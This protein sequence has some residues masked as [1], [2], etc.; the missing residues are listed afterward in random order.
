MLFI[1][2]RTHALQEYISEQLSQ[3]KQLGLIA[4]LF[5][6]TAIPGLVLLLFLALG[7]VL[8]NDPDLGLILTVC[9]I[10][11]QTEMSSALI[12]GIFYSSELVN[13]PFFS[14]KLFEMNF[15]GLHLVII[16]FVKWLWVKVYS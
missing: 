16:T 6:Y 14:S 15:H 8:I 3:L 11:A 13:V 9:L 7:K 10:V 1:A 12:K 4:M 2:Y 5:M